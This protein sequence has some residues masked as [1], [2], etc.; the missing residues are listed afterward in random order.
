VGTERARLKKRLEAAL[1]P[2]WGIGR[3]V[4]TA[5]G[6]QHPHVVHTLIEV[7]TALGTPSYTMPEQVRGAPRRAAT[8]ARYA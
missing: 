6:L 4:L 5:P 2:A 8:C 7:G 3:E 1:G